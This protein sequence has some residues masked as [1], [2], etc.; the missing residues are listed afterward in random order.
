MKLNARLLLTAMLLLPALP[1]G[2]QEASVPEPLRDRTGP[3]AV[4]QAL[5]GYVQPQA[6]PLPAEPLTAPPNPQ[7]SVT[8]SDI[9]V[10]G[11]PALSAPPQPGWQPSTDPASGLALSL[12]P[13]ETFRVDW[14]R[15]QFL[16]SGLVGRPVP[17]DRVVALVQL[18]NLAF[19]R[20]GYINSGILLSGPAPIDGAVLE[21]AVVL[22]RLVPAQPG[23]SPV[24]VAWPGG[25]RDGLSTDYIRTRMPSAERVPLNAIALERDFRL[26]AENPAIATIN[27]DLRPG[28][29]PGEATL[30]LTVDPQRRLD[31][32]LIAA[33]S[34]SPSIG[35]ERYSAGGSV[36]SLATA[37]DIFSGE[38]GETS[39]RGDFLIG[40]EAPLFGRSTTLSL[41][42][43]RNEAAVIDRPLRPLD[44]EARDWNL[45]GGLTRR[46]LERP[47]T[48]GAEPGTWISARTVSVGIRVAHRNSLT[49][50][51]GRP[52]SFSP[53][54]VN[55]RT[56]YTALRLTGDWV[57]RGIAEVAALSLTLTQGLGGTKSD[58]PGLPTP[59]QQFR[60][61]LAQLS[62]AR[63][64]DHTGLELRLRLGGQYA[65]GLL[66]SGERFSAGGEY[67][68]RGYRETLLL[69]DAGANAS[70][71]VARPFSISGGRRNAAGVDWG[72]FS[73][74]AFVDG[75]WLHNRIDPQPQP[76][77]IA[78]AGASLTWVPSEAIFARITFAEDLKEA[79]LVGSKD[80]Q[81]RG[82][83]FRLTIRPLAFFHRGGGS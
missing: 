36:R 52:F 37:G 30:A 27:A 45:E 68:V 41:R 28:A 48:P 17:L 72:A 13:G 47:L 18:V 14:V 69:A 24:T 15:R 61:L 19:V 9:R 49:T 66:Y 65:D 81:D 46:L 77:W 35:G 64:L 33:N 34:R 75:A 31:F 26:L 43:G 1:V 55:G 22:G 6:L 82:I 44:I 76:D 10:S 62:Y 8:F 29:R 56:E 70:I 67:T 39:G 32:Y 74:S 60:A 40:Y 7:G 38:Y 73:F 71:E 51:L 57:Q 25:N 12:Q 5:P 16:A 83:Q 4:P 20:N 23:G 53:G 54:A 80:L 50:L 2:A 42:G 78:G 63:R 21:V 59:D 79:P 11:D 58:L 3:N